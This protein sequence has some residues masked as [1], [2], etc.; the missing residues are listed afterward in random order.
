MKYAFAI[1]IKKWKTITTGVALLLA[2]SMSQAQTYSLGRVLDSIEVRNPGLQQYALKT[3]ASFASGTAARAWMA[4]VAG[5]GLS[6]FPYSS[7]RKMNGGPMP[8]KMLMLRLEQ[9]F[10]NFS[11]QRKAETY[12]RSYANQNKDD[13]ATMKNMLFAKAKMAYYDAFI[14]QKKLAVLR[15]QEQQLQLLIKISEGRLAYNKADLPNIYKARATLSDLKSTR[16]NLQSMT[17]QAISILNALMNLPVDH[18]LQIDTTANFQQHQVAILQIDTAYVQR[19]RSDIKHTQDEIHSMELKQQVIA[20]MG[21]PTFGITWDNM[22]MNSGMY[23]YSAMA[24]LSIP[25][26]P[27]FSKGYK[28]KITAMDFQIQAMEKRKENQVSGALGNIRKDWLKLRSAK[29]DLQIFREEVIP[30]YAKTYQANLNAFSENNGDIY[31]TL[32]AWNDL[33]MKKMEYYDKLAGL[34]NLRV[35]LE[36]EMQQP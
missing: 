14:A 28:S 21:K 8:R 9:M 24:S 18:P 17:D 36:T 4:P 1:G 2:G 35:M 20:A 26:A 27:W 16:I 15:V 5:V 13:R 10:P 6:E 3:Q 31:E 32:M 11:Q 25:I 12:E 19:N 34:L 30:A 7:G 29:E 23:M 22:R 33:T